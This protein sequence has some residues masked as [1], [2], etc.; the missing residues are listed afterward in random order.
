MYR[1]FQSEV[2]VDIINLLLREE[3]PLCNKDLYMML[4]LS[5]SYVSSKVSGIIDAGIITA[6]KTGREVWY[7]VNT[8]AI[9]K[10]L[11]SSN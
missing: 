7:S 10:D 11:L 3:R 4:G 6:E 5:Q 1:L 2:A 9:P 8:N